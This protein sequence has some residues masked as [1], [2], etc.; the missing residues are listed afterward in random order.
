M[1]STSHSS[2]TIRQA[3][4]LALTRDGR[5]V[6]QLAA[7][8]PHLGIGPAQAPAHMATW[9]IV[10]SEPLE[11]LAE[12]ARAALQAAER[13]VQRSHRIARFDIADSDGDLDPVAPAE[14][15]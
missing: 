10:W 15:A 13:E 2:D 14:S 7:L 5:A 4:F 8:F 1:S 6:G 11:R 9:R 3:L 12:P